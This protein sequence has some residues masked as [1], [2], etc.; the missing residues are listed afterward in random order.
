MGRIQLRTLL[1]RGVCNMIEITP[2]LEIEA[3]GHRLKATFSLIPMVCVPVPDDL[4][5]PSYTCTCRSTLVN[6]RMYNLAK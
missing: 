2:C 1:H 3:I 4:P 5:T 6:V